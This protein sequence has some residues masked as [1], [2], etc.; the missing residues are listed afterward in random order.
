MAQPCGLASLRTSTVNRREPRRGDR[1]RRRPGTRE[2]PQRGARALADGS[3]GD[4][5][6]RAGLGWWRDPR[7]TT[8]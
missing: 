6:D 8:G 3:A 7:D 1:R 4:S 5:S 2:A